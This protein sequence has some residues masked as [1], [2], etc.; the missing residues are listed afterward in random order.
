LTT[1]IHESSTR[2][3][4]RGYRTV[5]GAPVVAKLPKSESPSAR[6]LASLQHE[7][8]VLRDIAS[9][10]VVTAYALEEYGN[11]LA[12]VLADVDGEP[13]SAVLASRRLDLRTILHIATRLAAILGAVHQRHVIH[14]DVKPH[15]I[16]FDS[17]SDRVEL[18]DFGIAARL[19]QETAKA[20][21]PEALEGT[22]AY[23]S[24]EQT[25]RMNRVID[26]RTDFYSLG[27]TLYEMLTGVLPFTAADPMELIHGHMARTPTPPHE[28]TPSVPEVIS[29]LVM[30]LLEKA[31]EDRYQ[32]SRGLEADLRKCSRRL[33]ESGNVEAFVLGRHDHAET[34]RIP[35]KLYGRAP[36]QQALLAAFERAGRGSAELFL[37]S[38]YAGIGKSALVS[39]VHKAI[40]DRGGYFIAG[41]FDQFNRSVPYA[42]AAQAFRELVRQILTE[43]P[44]RLARWRERLD[45]ALGS[46]GR[47]L[48]DLI[49]ELQALI[50]KPPA[51]AALGP[52]ESQNRFNLVFKNFVQVFAEAERPLV[53]FLDDLH[54]AD[55]AS[56]KLIQV[57]LTD[58][59]IGHLLVIGAYRDNEVD[60][61]HPLRIALDELPR[62]GATVNEITLRPLAPS[63]VVELLADTLRRERP[64]VEPLARVVLE[65]TQN[66]PFFL[67]QFLG[68]LYGEGLI[69]FDR[70]PGAW[71]WDLE[72][73]TRCPVA[74]DVVDFMAAKIRR[75]APATQ[76]ILELAA[77]IGHQFDLRTLSVI[78][79]T[80]PSE[81]A[82]ILWP[83]LQEGLVVPLDADYRLVHEPSA[84]AILGADA[85]IE[86]RFLHDR[87]QQAAYSLID[88]SHKREV[89]LRIG[90]LMLAGRSPDA[91]GDTLFDVAG[92]LNA[93]AALI[94]TR[95]EK[96]ALAELN[97][98]AGRRAKAATAHR[99]AAD[100][101][102]SGLE[103]L[104]E[105]AWR[106]H[107]ELTLALYTE[108]AE[109][110]YMS[111]NFEQ[112]LA[113]YPD[114]LAHARTAMDKVGV[115]FLHATQLQLQGRHAEAIQ[116]QLAA[117]ALLGWSV[118]ESG[119]VLQ[120]MLD[121][122]LA[123]VAV[124][125]GG[126]NIED[127]VRA[128]RMLSPEAIAMMGIL[129][130][131]LYAAYVNSNQTLANLSLVKMT[132]LS[133]EHGNSDLS[134]FGYVGYG[135]VIG[136]VLGDHATGHRFGKMAIELCEQFDNQGM[137]CKT[138]F[139]FAADLNSWSRP[140]RSSDVNYERAYEMGV[141]SGDWVTVGYTIIQSGSDRLTRGM[142]LPDLAAICRTHRAFLRRAK[143]HDAI[144]LLLAGVIQ[145]IR[146]L[147]GRTDSR[148]TFDGQGFTEAA[149]LEKYSGSPYHLAWL[150]YAKIRS[151]YLFEDRPSWPGL[152][153]K[154]SIVENFVPTHAKVPETFFHVALIR[155][156]SCASASGEERREHLAQIERLKSKLTVWAGY[157]PENIR[158]KLLLIEAEEARI[159]GR[160]AEAMDLYDRA[161]ESAAQ[162]EY[163]NNQALAA[164]LYGRF[165]LEQG[166]AEV[167]GLYL[168]K[169]SDLY[170][171]WGAAAK[172]E[173]LATKYPQFFSLEPA[174][175]AGRATVF[176]V[177][178]TAHAV[179]GLL[180]LATVLRAGQAI[181]SGNVVEKILDQL[182]RIVLNSAGAS[183]GFLLLERGGRMVIEAT[184]AVDPDIVAVGLGEPLED[185]GDLA[186]SVVLHVARTR[187]AVV[188]GDAVMD[189]R[190]A[191]DPYIAARRPRSILCLA[192]LYQG[193]PSGILYLENNLACDAF[194]ADR[195]EVL[196][197]LSSQAA[198]AVE[199]ARL[200]AGIQEAKSQLQQSND[201][202]EREVLSRTNELREANDRL[203]NSAVDLQLANVRLARELS[204]RER[205]E[206]A[207]AQLQGEMTRMQEA[208]LEEM[209]TPLI[210][211]TDRMVV[212]PLIGT[213]D[214]RRSQRVL[215]AVLQGAQASRARVVIL[216]VTGMK[217][218]DADA[219]TA[220][221]NAAGALR[222][223][224][225][226]AVLTGVYPEM[227]QALVA[228]GAD[229]GRLVI[230]GTLQ[231]GIAYGMARTGM[232][233]DGGT[234]ARRGPAP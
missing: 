37:V 223:L 216:D 130:G 135:M 62:L 9:P 149:Y 129:Q 30:K 164:E 64:L 175:H 35:Q 155:L 169:A 107:Y 113:L 2:V 137:Q 104:P 221:I 40:A 12:L 176:N 61:S 102:R 152:V 229:L 123:A 191:A 112:A 128:P 1:R 28:R 207:R 120:A 29:R 99:A 163:I 182:M 100:Y 106:H 206:S 36:E 146:N 57:L 43:R 179:S 183:R 53:V 76:R 108:R 140:I 45:V 162:N 50:S 49:P 72:G 110:E 145:P 11:G 84:E 78:H 212:M 126:R 87:V 158:H 153:D 228:V 89:H 88:D 136:A 205:T 73:I 79:E 144:D 66:H 55:P 52:T 215:E 202:L 51:I 218:F 75:L 173:D 18:I 115:R 154:L 226:E 233:W 26:H 232:S 20:S 132:T 139:L 41:K 165:W 96:R 8:A 67:K 134:S 38:G 193:R 47:L 48:V 204:E 196:Q 147:Q 138:N 166:R 60:E 141:E 21:S 13:L 93:G 34:L 10:G 177:V 116:I 127:L 63:D 6:E 133:L 231:S 22:L 224:G 124:G 3:L 213:M 68:M 222:L 188:L 151:A 187:E 119:E 69:R 143:N 219:A 230:R 25:G 95:E 7:Y 92:H 117:L 225:A 82:R 203:Q 184:I 97:L 227:A 90:R 44:E 83:A 23:L 46:S 185:R 33:R 170:E 31:A 194:G 168:R 197:L 178:N 220:L 16:M 17:G 148:F 81:A 157:C 159:A 150:Y 80:P 4:Y 65:R 19:S 210:P 201:H 103:L 180:D 111:G 209:S 217:Q 234:R 171:R 131:L 186:R 160:R 94:D 121:K 91:L 195:I 174:T 85:R 142:R 42:S 14:K 181:S 109:A 24:P 77:C 190:F 86:Y 189:E 125:L 114:A 192:L 5:D 39:E 200:Y 70:V 32:S 58:P 156:A 172:V 98:A 161:I 27:V 71:I 59:E 211:I 122:E 167:A 15:N 118:P 214:A 74:D 105:D 208:A 198:I 199:N 56:L 54:W 101:F